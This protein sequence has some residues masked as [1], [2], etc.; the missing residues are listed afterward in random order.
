MAFD[1]ESSGASAVYVR[2]CSGVKELARHLANQF[3]AP[4]LLDEILES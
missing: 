3:C 2:P 4:D 1:T